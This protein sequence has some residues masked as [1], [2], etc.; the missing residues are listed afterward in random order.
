MIGNMDTYASLLKDLCSY[1][2]AM[3]NLVEGKRA[4]KSLWETL[5]SKITEIHGRMNAME[6]AEEQRATKDHDEYVKHIID[7][8]NGDDD[9]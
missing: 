2:L 1:N 7:K 3:I 8:I 6:Q 9:E 4:Y 5:S